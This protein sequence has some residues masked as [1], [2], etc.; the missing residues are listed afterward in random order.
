ME[1]GIVNGFRILTP[2]NGATVSILSG[3]SEV[4]P[5]ASLMG[6]SGFVSGIANVVLKFELELYKLES[7]VKYLEAKKYHDQITPYL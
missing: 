4:E 3:N 6:A 5:Y 7:E 1:S 2:L